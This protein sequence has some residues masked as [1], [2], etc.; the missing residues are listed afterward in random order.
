MAG[1]LSGGDALEAVAR[2]IGRP[3]QGWQLRRTGADIT[4]LPML[5]LRVVRSV[6]TRATRTETRPGR[7]D[8]SGLPTYEGEL[9]G[10]PAGP[11]TD[12]VR[13][14]EVELVLSGLVRTVA[15]GAPAVPALPGSGETGLPDRGGVCRLRGG[16]VVHL[17]RRH[18]QAPRE[19]SRGRRGWCADHLRE[20]R[21]A[22]VGLPEVP[23]PGRRSV[24][25][26]RRHGLA[27]LPGLRG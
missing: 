25:A 13:P 19:R 8:P 10:H 9:G 15:C 14:H 26:V 17:V 24:P 5:G 2:H 22:P 18:R 21:Q 27:E 23:W 1:A 7:Y 4:P 6:E 16:G 3:G 12:P 11:P 20:V